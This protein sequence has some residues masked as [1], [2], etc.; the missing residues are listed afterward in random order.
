MGKKIK[1]SDLKML[2][3][4][5]LEHQSRAVKWATEYTLPELKRKAGTR[6]RNL[7]IT[8]FR[9]YLKPQGLD[10]ITQSVVLTIEQ[11]M[12]PVLNAIHHPTK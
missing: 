1:S 11:M 5:S 6:Y 2:S 9:C 7:G 12:W 3:F 8:S 10:E 4:R